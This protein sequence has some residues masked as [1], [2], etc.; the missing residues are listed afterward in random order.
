[1]KPDSPSP[2]S[3][4]KIFGVTE[5]LILLVVL[6]TSALTEAFSVLEMV[7]FF[8]WVFFVKNFALLL[9][10]RKLHNETFGAFLLAITTVL[11]LVYA[12]WAIMNIDPAEALGSETNLGF[13][14]YNLMYVSTSFAILVGLVLLTK[15][16]PNKSNKS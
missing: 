6:A 8:V 12:L 16:R 7:N 5:V 15:P 9:L 2:A 10:A 1:M 13:G 3:I 14:V 11:D 4:W